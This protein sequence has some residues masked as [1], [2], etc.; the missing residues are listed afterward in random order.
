M[1][2]GVP[3]DL[4]A[5]CREVIEQGDFHFPVYYKIMFDRLLAIY[6]GM[7]RVPENDYV[8]DWMI[9]YRQDI[10]GKARL[11]TMRALRLGGSGRS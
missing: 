1:K 8:I 5:W 10:E 2:N 3:D 7:H 6:A 11:A 4:A 9:R